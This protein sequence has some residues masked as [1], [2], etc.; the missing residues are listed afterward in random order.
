VSK[1]ARSVENLSKRKVTGGR[2]SA[3]RRRRAFESDGYAVET[4]KGEDTRAE[5]RI[6]GGRVKIII[7]RAQYANFLDTASKKSLKVKILKVVKNPASRD[8]ERRGVI[9]EGVIIETDKGLA[10]VV[11]RPGQDGVINT[12]HVR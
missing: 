9:T 2:R 10:K 6:R 4:I 8:Y 7:K 12:I 11:S 3:S 1:L 5:K